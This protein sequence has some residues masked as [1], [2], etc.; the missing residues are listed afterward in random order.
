MAALR[1]HRRDISERL[2]AATETGESDDHDEAHDTM[3]SIR[4]LPDSVDWRAK[5]VTTPP[6]Q[7]VSCFHFLPDFVRHTK[8]IYIYI[9]IYIRI[10]SHLATVL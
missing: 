8:H 2:R 10:L 1:G 5:N 4:G 9:Y 6:K 7:Q 3:E